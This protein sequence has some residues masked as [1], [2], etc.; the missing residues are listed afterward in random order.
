MTRNAHEIGVE[1]AMEFMDR[2]KNVGTA[3]T[4]ENN[5]NYLAS[6]VHGMFSDRT[7]IKEILEGAEGV[8]FA[9]KDEFK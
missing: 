1:M 6:A 3:V 8:F 4:L 9:R 5:R 7:V 2:H